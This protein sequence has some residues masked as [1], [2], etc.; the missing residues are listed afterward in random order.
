[1]LY[2][3]HVCFQ[4]EYPLEVV[5][6]PLLDLSVFPGREK[7]VRVR[8]ELKRSDRVVVSKDGLVAVAEVQAP[9]FDVFV[10][11]AGGDERRVGRDVDGRGR[12]LVAV[13]REKHLE[14]VDEENL[15]GGVQEGDGDQ[16]TVGADL[17]TSIQSQVKTRL[18]PIQVEPRC[19]LERN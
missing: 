18:N 8:H 15:D 13:E 7:H 11:A 10:G 17:K 19:L 12:Q 2:L 9:N 5:G 6:V 1:M 14:A 16:S 3:V 4:R